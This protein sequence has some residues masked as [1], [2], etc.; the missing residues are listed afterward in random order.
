MHLQKEKNY[1][2]F[3][4]SAAKMYINNKCTLDASARKFIKIIVDGFIELKVL[5]HTNVC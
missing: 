1:S 5:F 4:Y 2:L 3:G